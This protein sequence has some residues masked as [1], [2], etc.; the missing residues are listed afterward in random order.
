MSSVKKLR[1]FEREFAAYCG[2]K[3]AIAVNSGTSAL[4]LA[5][6]AAG[7]GPGDE[8]ITVPFT[9]VATRLGDLLHRRDA[10]V[11]RHRAVTRSP[12]TRRKLE[13]AITPRTKAILPVHLYGQMADMDAILAIANRHGIAVIE[14]A[15]QAHG[16][17]YRR[18][19]R[20]QPRRCRAASAS[21][22]ARTLAHAA[23]AASSSR[24]TMPRR[25][26]CGCC[27]TGVRR[28]AITTC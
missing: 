9:F 18:Q 26:R 16:A 10:G 6:L 22:P 5:L 2:A 25:S 20:G 24:A 15:C 17:E 14:D 3:H 11:R 21:I 1:A 13:T 12:W 27:A 19:A 23:K 4:H 28:S 7:V 8:V